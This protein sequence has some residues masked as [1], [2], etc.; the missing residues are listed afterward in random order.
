MICVDYTVFNNKN[1][2]C[3]QHATPHDVFPKKSVYDDESW[4]SSALHSPQPTA[5]V[6]SHSH[7]LMFAQVVSSVIISMERP[8]QHHHNNNTN[9]SNPRSD[10]GFSLSVCSCVRLSMAPHVVHTW[11]EFCVRVCCAVLIALPPKTILKLS[12]SQTMPKTEAG[13]I[14]L[15]LLYRY[16]FSL[17]FVLM[18]LLLLLKSES[19]FMYNRSRV[20]YQILSGG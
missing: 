6:L 9:N 11:L 18:T 5:V 3:V 7:K 20:K 13:W 1:H 2:L 12:S 8:H 19:E 16:S 10:F 15:C 4:D 14:S 17:F